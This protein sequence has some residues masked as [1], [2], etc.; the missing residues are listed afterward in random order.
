MGRFSHK[1]ECLPDEAKVRLHERNIFGLYLA[2]GCLLVLRSLVVVLFNFFVSLDVQSYCIGNIDHAS[3]SFWKRSL[4][5][6]KVVSQ[7]SYGGK[8]YIWFWCCFQKQVY[9]LVRS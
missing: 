5:A 6:L 1:R 2:Q 3:L 7:P 4:R 9:S 8:D